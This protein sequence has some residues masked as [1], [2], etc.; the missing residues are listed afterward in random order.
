M[1]RRS[2]S[3]LSLLFIFLQSFPLQ[4][5][6]RLPKLVSDSMVIQR[7]T[8][9]RIWGWADANEK[10]R[11]RFRGRSLST[12]ANAEGE[13]QVWMPATRAGGPYNMTITGR[14]TT[15]TIRDILVGDVWLCSGQSNMVHYLELHQDRYAADIAEANYP[16]IR[17]FTVPTRAA[18]EG[19]ANDLP[20]GNWITATKGNILR[21]SVVAYFFAKKLYEEYGIP[22]GLINA[23]VGG[24]PIESW[25]SEDGLRQFPDI[26]RRIN[27]NK[28]TARVN[29]INRTAAQKR[30]ELDTLRP[31]DKGLHGPVHWYDPRFEPE[32]WHAISIP[33]Y[34]EDQGIRNLDGIVWYRREIDVPASMTDKTVRLSLGRIVDAD[35]VYINGVLVGNK[36]YQYP[37]RRY[38][39]VPGVLKSGKNVITVRVTNYG[40]KGGFVPDKPYYLAVAGDTIDLTGYWKYEVGSAFPRLRSPQGIN[41]QNQPTASFNAMLA[42]IVP[43]A[44]KG[45]IWYQGE[46]DADHPETYEALQRALIRDWRSR[47]GNLPFLFVQLPNFMEVTYQPSESNWA[48]LRDAQRRT[49]SEPNTAMAV[50]IDL[51]E[52]NDIHPGNKKPVGERLALAAQKIAY[53]DNVVYSGPLFHSATADGN[54]VRITFDHIGTGLM[55]GTNGEV[56]GIALAGTDKEFV[57]ADAYIEGNAVVAKADGISYPVYVRYAW[58]DN[59]VGANLRNKEGLPASP[60]EGQVEGTDELWYG[61]KAAVVLTYDDALDV[62]LDNVIPALNAR[63]FK[64]SFY[65]SAAFPGSKNR[66]ADWRR[67]AREGHELGNHTLFHP[68]DGSGR[69]WV[70]PMNDLSR[71]TTEEIVREIDMTNTFLEAIDGK[72]E[73]TFAYT[74]GDTKTGEGSFSEAIRDQFVAMRGVRPRLNRADSLDLANINCYGVDN[75]NADHLISWAEQAHKEHA[76]L[77]IL[78]HGVGGGHDINVDLDKHNKFLDYLKEN[79]DAFWVTTLLEASKHWMQ[80]SSSAISHTSSQ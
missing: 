35:Q 12:T 40:G 56:Q 9:V 27:L 48:A 63:G 34:W 14:D 45:F 5:G 51:G 29:Q 76:L 78:F 70:S 41:V 10:I 73:R 11:I 69:S 16:Q 26:T 24:T 18:L 59:P 61:K 21:F 32:G 80:K 75:N 7:D 53:G 15:I 79:E 54:K 37:Q 20:S 23:S 47:W 52:W 50:A 2:L 31:P 22:M 74:C 30:R 38:D 13:W 25:T 49:L 36:T 68:C 43:F 42:P 28:D 67:A 64:G 33:G 57:W 6:V 65:L 1:M 19:P 8:K 55:A 17:Q 4:A 46:S 58:A 66:I 60:F 77:V 44:L 72:K 3:V 39:I 62:H 71:Y